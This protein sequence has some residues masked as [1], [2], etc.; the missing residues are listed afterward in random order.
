LVELFKPSHI[1]GKAG[2]FQLTSVIQSFIDSWLN[3]SS[4]KRESLNI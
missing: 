1:S 2:E 4:E 3:Y